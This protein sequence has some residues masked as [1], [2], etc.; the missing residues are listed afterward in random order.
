MS[1]PIANPARRV[2]RR[3]ERTRKEALHSDGDVTHA[4]G[5]HLQTCHFSTRP[6]WTAAA[7]IDNAVRRG[8]GCR[9]TA[10][11]VERGRY[12]AP[13]SMTHSTGAGL[14]S[15]PL[16]SWYYRSSCR[17]S[18]SAEVGTKSTS[19]YPPV[20]DRRW[21]NRRCQIG[22]ESNRTTQRHM[23]EEHLMY[24][25]VAIMSSDTGKRRPRLVPNPARRAEPTLQGLW[26]LRRG[27][28]GCGR[29]S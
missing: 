20:R 19:C 23:T 17:P 5:V 6:G 12:C 4:P 11:T 8:Q 27:H 1:A 22:W 10:P 18:A 7:V 25:F 26:R 29:A 13:L 9:R 16:S 28:G 21:V 15:R 24:S 2:R 14:S 3:V